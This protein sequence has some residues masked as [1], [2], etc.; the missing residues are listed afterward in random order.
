MLIVVQ[1]AGKDNINALYELDPAR[2]DGVPFQY[3]EVVRDK[4]RRKH[5]HAADCECCRDVSD[6][7]HHL[8]LACTDQA[9]P[10]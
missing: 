3:D 5:M 2:N 4:R 8:H 9:L 7:L 6:L 10:T 1:R